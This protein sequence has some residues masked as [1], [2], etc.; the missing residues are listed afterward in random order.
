MLSFFHVANLVTAQ[1]CKLWLLRKINITSI[2]QKRIARAW[3]VVSV[4]LALLH[5]YNIDLI[6]QR[7]RYLDLGL[8]F[9]AFRDIG[10]HLKKKNVPQHFFGM[11]TNFDS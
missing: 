1:L 7:V 5:N 9:T 2:K 10:V 8:K 3:H 11:F 4:R 6:Y